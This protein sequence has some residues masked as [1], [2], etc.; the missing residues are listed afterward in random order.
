M[1]E[2]VGTQ[3]PWRRG[4]TGC[5]RLSRQLLVC[6]GRRAREDRPPL[7]PR[8]SRF[9]LRPA[10]QFPRPYLRHAG[11]G[12]QKL[13]LP[14][15]WLGVSRVY[16]ASSSV[17]FFV[18]SV[19]PQQSFGASQ[20]VLSLVDLVDAPRCCDCGLGVIVLASDRLLC[21]GCTTG[22]HSFLGSCSIIK[23]ISSSCRNSST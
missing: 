21:L 20:R 3:G 6:G 12:R 5:C 1:S 11:R 14:L 8:S 10:C 22:H 9:R 17:S 7:L 15:D 23:T 19:K 2:R 4:A 13:T 16:L 18:L